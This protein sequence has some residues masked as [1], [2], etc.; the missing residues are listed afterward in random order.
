M[1]YGQL[2]QRAYFLCL[3]CKRGDALHDLNYL[4]YGELEGLVIH[5]SRL[6]A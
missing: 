5:L 4:S 1:T 3:K 2:L 6:T